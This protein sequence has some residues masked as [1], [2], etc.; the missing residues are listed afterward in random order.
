MAE[1]F[2]RHCVTRGKKTGGTVGDWVDIAPNNDQTGVI[3]HF[4]PR[5]NLLYR[6]DH[7]RTKQFAANV[8]RLLI[9][10]AVMPTF[11]EEL[12]GRALVGALSANITPVI[13]LNKIDITSHLA[14]AKKRL[15]PCAQLGVPILEISALN[16]DETQQTCLPYLRNQV[17]LLLGQSGMGKSTLINALVKNANALTREHSQAAN[18]GRH[19]TTTTRLYHLAEGGDLID[20]PGFQAFGLR[21]LSQAEIEKGFPEFAP[22]APQCRFYN[23]LHLQEPDCGVLAALATGAIR[24][25]RHALYTRILAENSITVYRHT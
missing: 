15:A 8:D 22:Y 19:T 13:I 2:L 24:P 25:T 3:E 10:V 12:I 14:Y 23:C 18:R 9:V 20:S 16:P 4:L 7:L 17:N 1:G 11:S 6:S 21:H 5:R